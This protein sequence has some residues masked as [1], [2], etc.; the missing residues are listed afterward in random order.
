MKAEPAPNDQ[1]AGSCI[2]SASMR[3]RRGGTPARQTSND[4]TEASLPLPP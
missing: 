1:L 2:A 3:H 4:T